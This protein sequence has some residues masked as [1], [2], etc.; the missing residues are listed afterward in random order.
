VADYLAGDDV[1]AIEWPER[2]RGVTPQQSLVVTIDVAGDGRRV[3]L[4]GR[5]TAAEAA[6]GG[7]E[8]PVGVGPA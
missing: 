6:L 1:V 4:V 2:A 7:L 5:G 3:T 8:L